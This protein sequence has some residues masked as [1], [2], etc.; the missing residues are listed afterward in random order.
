MTL[1]GML[2]SNNRT[3]GRKKDKKQPKKDKKSDKSDNESVISV[4]SSK[5]DWS[6]FTLKRSPK[7]KTDTLKPAE[8]SKSDLTLTKKRSKKNK[9]ERQPSFTVPRNPYKYKYFE[10]PKATVMNWTPFHTSPSAHYCGLSSD[11]LTD[12]N[13]KISTQLS[14]DMTE[15]STWFREQKV[16][17]TRS[18]DDL[19]ATDDYV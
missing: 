1:L 13:Q 9:L 8:K 14:Q 3:M 6:I 12:L 7:V 10:K 17:R 16:Y 5:S 4:S 18:L 11:N 15:I 2:G 19:L